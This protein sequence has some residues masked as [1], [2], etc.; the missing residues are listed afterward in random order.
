M[1]VT[2]FSYP[3]NVKV[4]YRNSST[5]LNNSV[6]KIYITKISQQTLLSLLVMLKDW[7]VSSVTKLCFPIKHLAG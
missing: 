5:D 6:I 3:W 7:K 1:N 4:V 2:M